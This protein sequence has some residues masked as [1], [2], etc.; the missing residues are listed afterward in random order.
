MDFL[1][2]PTQ[3]FYPNDA[4]EA[5]H[6]SGRPITGVNQENIEAESKVIMEDPH[7]TYKQIEA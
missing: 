5:D 4:T 7:S 3:K 1:V 2:L 6:R